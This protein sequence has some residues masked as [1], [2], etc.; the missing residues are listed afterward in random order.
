MWERETDGQ[1][2]KRMDG[3]ADVKVVPGLFPSRCCTRLSGSGS[4]LSAA[5][6]RWKCPGFYWP[7]LHVSDGFGCTGWRTDT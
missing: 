5:A 2:D 7:S 3:Q 6:S 1:T 4:W